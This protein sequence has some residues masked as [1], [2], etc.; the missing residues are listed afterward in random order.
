MADGIQILILESVRKIDSKVDTL[1]T[2]VA[3]LTEKDKSVRGRVGR[4]EKLM[5]AVFG[6][7]LIGAFIS[8]CS[9]FTLPT[10]PPSPSVPGSPKVD[11]L[12]RTLRNTVALQTAIGDIFCGGVVAEGI[13]MTAAHCV[14]D[15]DPFDVLYR[16]KTYP[17]TVTFMWAHYDLAFIDAVGARVKGTIPM[18]EWAPQYG[19]R[20]VWTGYPGGRELLMGKGIVASPLSTWTGKMVVFGGFVPGNSGGPVLDESGKLMGIISSYM[21]YATHITVVGYAIPPEHI[22]EALSTL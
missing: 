4:I 16:G 1:V 18:T 15:G 2:D 6:A 3:T 19:Q 20:V 9:M 17:G 10:P 21:E 5:L 22:K 12:A 13:F 14:D 11:I 8:G 7:V